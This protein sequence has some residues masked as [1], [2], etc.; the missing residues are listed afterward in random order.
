[1][2]GGYI[3]LNK[4]THKI[5]VDEVDRLKAHGLK[6]DVEPETR[7]IVEDLTGYSYDALWCDADDTV[8]KAT[9][10]ATTLS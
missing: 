7:R 1:M 6:Q 5:F 10:S 4:R 2:A 9:K 3:H 8:A